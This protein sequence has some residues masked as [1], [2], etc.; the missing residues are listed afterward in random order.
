MP[1]SY[2]TL[3][4]AIN[5][6]MTS[7]NQLQTYAKFE[8]KEEALKLAEL[9]RE[10]DIEYMIEDAEPAF[11]PIFSSNKVNN[12]YRFKIKQQDFEKAGILLTAAPELT[13]TDW[14]ET[15]HYIFSFTDE[16]LMDLVA[17]RDEWSKHDYSL[18]L[19]ILKDRGK[20]LS[21]E[22][23]AAMK[24]KRIEDLSQPENH[25][26][27]WIYIGYLSAILGGFFGILIGWYLLS[28]KK[29][30]PNE[31]MAPAFS[32]S[33]RKHGM[34]MLV[35]GVICFILFTANKIINH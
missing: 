1:V 4:I 33:G 2:T 22:E 18:A 19:S 3:V 25:N 7:E 12:A 6:P 11:D 15:R 9:F 35:L 34:I 13:N 27:L 26:T 23:I 32:P 21:A 28:A 20:E 16:E 29:K 31:D 30:L 10:N 8:N 14:K 24:I 5:H 17:K